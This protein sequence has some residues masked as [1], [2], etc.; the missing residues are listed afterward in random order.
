MAL[1]MEFDEV[2]SQGNNISSHSEDVT[3][4]QNWLN[5]VVNNQLP[6]MW[7]GSGYEGFQQRVEELKPSFDAMR[8]L[9]ED[10]GKGVVVNANQYREFDQ[11]AGQA[12]RG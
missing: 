12:N 8:Q 4:L 6:S 11:Q 3:T 5:D 1:K 9:I 2:I 10:I 7:T